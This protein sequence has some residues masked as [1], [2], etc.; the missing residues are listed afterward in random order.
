MTHDNLPL[1][2]FTILVVEDEALI[3]LD[4]AMTLEEAGADVIGPCSSV[5]QA[6]S[7]IE[8]CDCQTSLHGAVLDVDLGKET[9]V[10]VAH[11]LQAHGVLFVFHTGVHPGTTNLLKDFDAPVIP[12]PSACETLIAGVAA[13]L[14]KRPVT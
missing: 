12:K 1:E 10:P 11:A 2:G 7:V 4:I 3:A 8:R 6:L 13:H 9:S 14:G 5:A